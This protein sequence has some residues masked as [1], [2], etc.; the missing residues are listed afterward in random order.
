MASLMRKKPRFYS[1][2]QGHICHQD[3]CNQDK[4]CLSVYPQHLDHLTL[5]DLGY[6]QKFSFLEIVKKMGCGWVDGWSHENDTMLWLHLASF[7]LTD[8]Q[9]S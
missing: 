7:K 9:L 2:I 3:K 1:M 5:D 4:C 6:K 8:Y